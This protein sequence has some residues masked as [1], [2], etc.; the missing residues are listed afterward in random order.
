MRGKDK[1]LRGKAEML[2]NFGCM[3]MGENA[4]SA[5]ILIYLDKVRIALWL[6]PGTSYARLAVANNSASRVDPA[7][8]DEGTQTQYHRS[9]IA[10]RI[11]DD[12]G[13]WQGV[14]VNLG[15][16]VYRLS[17]HLRIRGG[18][19][20]PRSER[21]RLTKTKCPAQVHDPQRRVRSEQ[22]GDQ[23]NRSLVWRGEK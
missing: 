17:Q 16:T 11:S 8:F 1:I 15:E 3:A 20:V 10:S 18:K 21:F 6:L 12:A 7:R 22:C 4:V 19:F 23:L 2:G 14:R 13:I 9:G 5:K